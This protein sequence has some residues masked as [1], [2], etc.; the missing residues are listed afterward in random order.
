MYENLKK[1]IIY[2]FKSIFAGGYLHLEDLII[3]ADM[4]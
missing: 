3:H 2:S 1:T 4:K